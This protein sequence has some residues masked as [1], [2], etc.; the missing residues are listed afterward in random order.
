MVQEQRNVHTAEFPQRTATDVMLHRQQVSHKPFLANFLSKN[1]PQRI[2]KSEQY[3]SAAFLC[4]L[5]R[6]TFSTFFFQRL[7]P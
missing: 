5:L 6:L 1:P 7:N 4:E 3:K 2:S